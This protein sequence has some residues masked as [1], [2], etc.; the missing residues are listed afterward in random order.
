MRFPIAPMPEPDAPEMFPASEY[1]DEER[2]AAQT[3]IAIYVAQV[4]ANPQAIAQARQQ[5]GGRRRPTPEALFTQNCASCHTLAAAGATGTVGPSLDGSS[6]PVAGIIEQI[7]Q[8][9]GGMPPF[10]GQLTDEQID[11]L[12]KYVDENRE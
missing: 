8:G 3:A 4:A 6:L 11:A 7:R 5:G 12:A 2:E 10:E 1:T 9:G